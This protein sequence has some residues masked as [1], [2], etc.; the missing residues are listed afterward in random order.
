VA[1]ILARPRLWPWC[2]APFVINVVVVVAVWWWSGRYAHHWI[3]PLQERDTW[4]WR[5]VG[6]IASGLAM[7]LR[8]IVALVA[9]VVIGNIASTPFNDFLSDRTDRIVSGWSDPADVGIMHKIGRTV[10]LVTQEVRRMLLFVAVSLLLLF[11]S[12]SGALALFAA[13]MQF[14][15]TAW[16]FALDYL[17]YPLERRGLLRLRQKRDFVHAHL[18]P[19]LGFGATMTLLCMVPLVNFFFIPLGVVGATLLYGRIPER[20]LDRA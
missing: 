2:L 17:A 13:A 12:L 16:F 1:F 19:C 4:L 10:V 7:L 8:A 15:V 14:I 11:A 20:E 3:A 5:M 6:F 18:A 9:F